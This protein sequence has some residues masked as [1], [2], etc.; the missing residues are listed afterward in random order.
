MP[1]KGAVVSGGRDVDETELGQQT[2]CGEH[3]AV[4]RWVAG[5]SWPL[6]PQLAADFVTEASTICAIDV[7]N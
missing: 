5:A 6:A 4:D 3:Q 2:S 7:S 1:G